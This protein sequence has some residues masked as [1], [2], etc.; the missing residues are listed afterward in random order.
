MKEKWGV[1][2]GM[3]RQATV[4]GLTGTS[5]DK[6]YDVLENAGI[7][8]GDAYLDGDKATHLIVTDRDVK[9][10]DRVTAEGTMA[11]GP[12]NDRGQRLFNLAGSEWILAS[13]DVSGKMQATVAQKSTN[14]YREGGEGEEQLI[15][16]SHEYPEDDPDYGGRIIHQNGEVDV[17]IPQRTFTIEGMVEHRAPWDIA[18]ALIG[19]VN[20]QTWMGQK[21]HTWMCTDVT[22]K[23]RHFKEGTGYYFMTYTFQHD[24]DTWNPTAVFIDDRTG[25]PPADL[26]EGTGYKYIRY[27]REVHFARELGFYCIGPAQ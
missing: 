13:R 7:P 26:V 25:R 4:T 14:L 11:Y 20:S 1:L 22:W 24:P 23:Y 12:F 18:E 27:H 16:L 21:K 8:A 17:H 2:V 6:M 3:T 19:G 5:W 10:I 15:Q 9:R